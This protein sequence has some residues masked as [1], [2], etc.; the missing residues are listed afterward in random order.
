MANV[1]SGVTVAF[2]GGSSG[3]VVSL[4][5]TEG[6]D[7]PIG[8]FGEYSP[9]AGTASVVTL[10]GGGSQGTYGPLSVSGA[11]ISLSL[12]LVYVETVDTSASVGDVVRYTTTMRIIQQ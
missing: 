4:S 10:D 1:A 11:G 6:A 2:P 12:P 9:N 5:V 3:E 7:K 8:F